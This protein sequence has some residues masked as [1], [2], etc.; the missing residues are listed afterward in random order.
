[1]KINS[2]PFIVI[3]S[4]HET[5]S[6]TQLIMLKLQTIWL[7]NSR[8]GWFSLSLSRISGS[9]LTC[10]FQVQTKS[11]FLHCWV[12]QMGTT[13]G[14]PF[15]GLFQETEPRIVFFGLNYSGTS[16]ILHQLKTGDTLSETR[17]LLTSYCFAIWITKKRGSIL[18]GYDIGSFEK[19]TYKYISLWLCY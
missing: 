17:V 12:K 15:S 8:R 4:D 9:S 7:W 18:L 10:D 19:K 16:S 6:N 3:S 14:K 13:F 5:D 11:I 2:W 1:M